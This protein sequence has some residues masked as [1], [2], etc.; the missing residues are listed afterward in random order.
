[1]QLHDL[2][3]RGQVG[4]VFHKTEHKYLYHMTDHHGFA[5]TITNNALK[6]L[7]Q[8][9]IST[10]Y[11]PKKNGVY[12]YSHYDFKFVMNGKALVSEYGGYEYDHHINVIGQGMETLD[13]REIRLKTPSIEP[14]KK[15]ML[16]A[17]LLMPM[18]SQTAIQ[19]LL[20]D[21]T[22]TTRF[23]SNVEEKSAAPRTIVAL[24]EMVVD[25]KRP[26]WMGPGYRKPTEM[27]WEFLKDAFRIHEKG[28][29]FQE[30]MMQLSDKYPVLDHWKKPLDSLTVKR[31]AMSKTMVA[32]LNKYYAGRRYKNVNV[33]TVQQII[34]KCILMLGL[35]DNSNKMILGAIR[36]AGLFNNVFVAPVDWGIILKP[37]MH[38]DIE[39]AI[40]GVEYIKD[41][42][43]RY[44][45]IDADDGMMK[46]GQHSGTD[47]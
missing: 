22:P 12:G 17:V 5:Y 45:N 20:Y 2:F 8:S 37:L 19:W 10:T 34:T 25:W 47:F 31:K 7:R 40:D 44:G 1:M 28:G 36:D 21:N 14:F 18:F 29:D 39:E 42:Y 9:D 41:R 23:L 27:E 6:P 3:E 30:G 13:E 33:A 11:D 46:Y 38:G 24:H 43:A 26:L 4:G 15:Y 16:G 35:G 32:M